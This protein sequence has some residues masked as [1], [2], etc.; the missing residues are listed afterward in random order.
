LTALTLQWGVAM[1]WA[2]HELMDTELGDVRRTD[3]LIAMVDAFARRPQ[4]SPSEAFGDPHQAKAAYRFWDTDACTVDGILSGHVRRTHQ[5]CAACQEVLVVQDS[6]EFNYTSHRSLSGLGY[7]SRPRTQGVKGHASLAVAPDGD[8][9]GVLDLHLWTRPNNQRGRRVHRNRRT[10]DQKETARWLRGVRAAEQ[11]LPPGGRAVV[12][13]DAEADVF[14]VLAAPRAPG[15]EILVRARHAKRLVNHPLRS[16]L[17]VVLSQ[18]IGTTIVEIPRADGR[19]GRQATLALYAAGATVPPPQ[20]HPRREATPVTLYWVLARE[21]SAPQDATA[22]SWLLA[23]TLPITTYENAVACLERY[24]LRWRIERFFYALKQGCVVEK[25]ELQNIERLKRALAT[26]AIVAWRVVHVLY[27]ARARPDADGR[28]LF[29][30]EELR[31][32]AAG[33]R[34]RRADNHELIT[35]AQAVQ[36]LGRLGGHLGRARDAPPGVKALWRGLRRL[37]D[38]LHGYLMAQTEMLHVGNA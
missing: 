10:T 5:R 3:R 34:R 19:P 8:V 28:E 31:L 36:R 37:T 23:T 6:T 15:V 18:P 35:N 21:E 13:G 38:Q 22:V 11:A 32:L 30:E 2:F 29:H 12:I 17:D 1:D 27:H 20:N 24:R 16:V 25:L 14:D 26:Y 33:D 9:L 7:T 4:A